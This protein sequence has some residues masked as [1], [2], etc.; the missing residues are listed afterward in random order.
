[1]GRG[2]TPK[3][4]KERWATEALRAYSEGGLTAVRVEPIA[5]RLGV[6][7]GSFYWHFQAGEE[8]ISAALERWE[9]QGTA[10]VMAQAEA[11]TDPLERVQSLFELAFSLRGASG[12]LVQLAADK[13]HPLV[14]PVLER[15]T[16]W[17]IAFIAEQFRALG[18]PPETAEQRAL[19]CY[20]LYVG[21]FAVQA[22]APD[23]LPTGEQRSRYIAHLVRT[24]VPQD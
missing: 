2:R 18:L 1:V 15:V 13:D 8:L 9:Q 6:T 12:L 23:A 21:T 22:A 24:L 20:S 10:V 16:R 7:K 17:R 5:R 19:L 4:S 3:A 14:H 11:I